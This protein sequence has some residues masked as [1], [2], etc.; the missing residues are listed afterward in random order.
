M[1]N[2]TDN[3]ESNQLSQLIDSSATNEEKELEKIDRKNKHEIKTHKLK[4]GFLGFLGQG[5]EKAVNVV[6]ITLVFIFVLIGGL[7][8]LSYTTTPSN[9]LISFNSIFLFLTNLS[10]LAFGYIF[11]I[12]KA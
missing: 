3:E 6:L 8:I 2:D 1:S 7:L 12:R 4:S 9:P 11:G 5:E 10:T